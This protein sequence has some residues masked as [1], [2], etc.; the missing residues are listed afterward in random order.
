M[1]AMRDDALPFSLTTQYTT[2]I[3]Q[4]SEFY[5]LIYLLCRT[6][7]QQSFARLCLAS[8]VSVI[9]M[10]DAQRSSAQRVVTI[11]SCLLP[12]GEI[13]RREYVQKSY[14]Y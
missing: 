2:H 7:A 9:P 14:A 1:R 4:F 3:F 8:N 6:D 12:E 10:L 11:I 5:K 13:F